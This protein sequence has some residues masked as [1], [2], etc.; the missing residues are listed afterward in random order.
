MTARFSPHQP[1]LIVGG[2]YSGQI[3]VWD[4]RQKSLPVSKTPL[5]DRGH[6]QPVCQVEHLGSHNARSLVSVSSD[7][8]LCTWNPEMLTE[9]TERM[10]L[11]GAATGRADFAV[12]SMGHPESDS[13]TLYFGG[14]DGGIHPVTNSAWRME[15]AGGGHAA[16]ANN[17][18]YR[19]HH[20][21]ITGLHFHPRNGTADFSEYALSSSIDWS[22]KVWRMRNPN[23]PG[24]VAAATPAAGQAGAPA[25][26]KSL[27]P[28]VSFDVGTDYVMD[29]R[30]SPTHPALFAAGGCDSNLSLWNLNNDLKSPS[31]TV[32]AK[33]PINKIRWDREGKK[34]A[35]GLVNGAVPLYDVAEV[36]TRAVGFFQ[37]CSHTFLGGR[38]PEARREHH[39]HQRAAARGKVDNRKEPINKHAPFVFSNNTFTNFPSRFHRFTAEVCAGMPS[40][41]LYPDRYGL[42]RIEFQHRNSCHNPA[43]FLG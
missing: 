5:N 4:M 18:V 37:R 40:K 17:D 25:T 21:P 16:L 3:L 1:N 34:I 11:S 39:A 23:A 43:T 6:T 32:A 12:T 22:V 9:P 28:H 30:W 31:S 36:R 19:G 20:G 29:A 7:G 35:L 41:R 38:N 24:S 42:R 26:A 2:T 27:A 13:A 8:V 33:A 14:E 15:R 10:E